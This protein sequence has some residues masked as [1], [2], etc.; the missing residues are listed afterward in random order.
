M[1]RNVG[2][3]PVCPIMQECDH[4]T[5]WHIEEVHWEETV[6]LRHLMPCNDLRPHQLD[7][8]CWC[9]PSED[10]ESPDF[11]IHNS[12]D[13]REAFEQGKAAN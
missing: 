3:L 6:T 9:T 4:P 5:G 7:P 13:G 12:A 10:T 8:S 11:W 2:D 1:T